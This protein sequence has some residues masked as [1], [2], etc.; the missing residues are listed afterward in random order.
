LSAYRITDVYLN[1]KT[2]NDPDE[3]LWWAKGGI[4]HGESWK[5]IKFLRHL[6]EEDHLEGREPMGK[7]DSFPWGRIS[8]ARDL[9]GRVNFIYFGEHQPNQWTNG[10]PGA[11]WRV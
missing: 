6:L 10:L 1:S 11:R 2:Y 5:W 4:L 7:K 3:L 8:G 9:S